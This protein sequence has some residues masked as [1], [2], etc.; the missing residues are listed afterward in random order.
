MK[1]HETTVKVLEAVRGD[2]RMSLRELM[3]ACDL[4]SPSVVSY[5]LL[6]LEKAEL[7]ARRPGARGIYVGERRRGGKDGKYQWHLPKEVIS[8][9]RSKANEKRFAQGVKTRRAKKDRSGD[10][11][12]TKLSAAE[13][14]ARIEMV[15]RKAE[16]RQQGTDVIRWNASPL[17]RKARKVG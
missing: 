12:L 17:F 10:G 4:A 3:A 6:K 16:S 2:P 1:L 14:A 11:P 7:I 8:E 5:H 15:A 13:L 9:M